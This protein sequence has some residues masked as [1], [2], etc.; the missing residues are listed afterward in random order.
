MVLCMCH[1]ASW[2]TV[3]SCRIDGN[4]PIS[5]SWEVVTSMGT[6]AVTLVCVLQEKWPFLEHHPE[7][8]TS[9]RDSLWE[10]QGSCPECLI[11]HYVHR[12]IP[13]ISAVLIVLIW[14]IFLLLVVKSL[15]RVDSRYLPEENAHWM[16]VRVWVLLHLLWRVLSFCL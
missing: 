15:S 4:S 13:G 8:V 9:S 12:V 6:S 5:D 3:R 16:G 1:G 7:Q 14:H 11:S 10:N 2:E